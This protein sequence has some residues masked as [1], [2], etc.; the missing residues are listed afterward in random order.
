MSRRAFTVIA[1]IILLTLGSGTA[2]LA[3]SGPL[4]TELQQVRAALAKY[5]SVELAERAG[6]I[7]TSPCEQSPAGAMGIHYLNPALLAPGI[8]PLQPEVLLYLPDRNGNLKL[9]GV[10][11]FSV[12]ADQTMQ[13]DSDRPSVFGQPFH[14]PM[15]GHAPGMPVHYD[16][17][18]WLY[19]ANPSGVFASWNPAISCP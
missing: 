19:E 8:D 2:V 12:A 3:R 1:T 10:E 6:Y 4:P 11:Y 5:H 9:V 7:P 17:H 18:V 14:G 13:D 16:L 15:L